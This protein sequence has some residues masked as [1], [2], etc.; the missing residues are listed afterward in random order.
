MEFIRARQPERGYLRTL[1]GAG[2]EGIASAKR[3]AGGRIL[4]QPVKTIAWKPAAVGATAGAL[5]ARLTGNRKPSAI[6]AGAF[7]G[8][9]VGFSAILAWT[10]RGFTARAAKKVMQLVNAARDEHWLETNPI[11]YA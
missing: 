1:I 7:V 11:D 4:A 5:G 8:G 6:A 2:F 3:E 9:L 10:S